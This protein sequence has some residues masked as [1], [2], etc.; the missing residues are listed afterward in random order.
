MSGLFLSQKQARTSPQSPSERIF[1]DNQKIVAILTGSYFAKGVRVIEVKLPFETM[2]IC[3]ICGD[4]SESVKDVCGDTKQLQV[5]DVT[6][7]QEVLLAQPPRRSGPSPYD[8]APTPYGVRSLFYSHPGT[9]VGYASGGFYP[10]LIDGK[11]LEP[12][13]LCIE[14]AQSWDE[15]GK[16]RAWRPGDMS[17]S[18]VTLAYSDFLLWREGNKKKLEAARLFAPR[19]KSLFAPRTKVF[20]KS[21]FGRQ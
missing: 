4:S 2:F 9:R 5:P 12:H 20:W 3:E 14:L 8:F 18:C 10:N 17:I 6:I 11:V 21:L 1:I 19:K 16:D 13:T 7:G 15:L